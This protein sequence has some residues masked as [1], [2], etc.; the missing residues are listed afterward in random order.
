MN[1]EDKS[2]TEEPQSEESGSKGPSSL[3]DRLKEGLNPFIAKGKQD[4]KAAKDYK[5]TGNRSSATNWMRRPGT[6]HWRF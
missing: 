2:V 5:R 3:I 6:G 4:L 1:D